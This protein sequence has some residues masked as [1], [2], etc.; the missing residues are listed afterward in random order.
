MKT[1]RKHQLLALV[2]L[3]A[4]LATVA[5][6]A[7]ADRA[8]E[9]RRPHPGTSE[10]LKEAKLIIEHNATDHDTGFQG[11]LDS[12]G[13]DRIEMIGPRGPQLDFKGVGSLG[14]L[15]LTELFFETVEPSNDDKPIAELLQDMPAGTYTFEGRTMIDGESSGRTIG[16]AELSHVIPD[17]PALLYPSENAVVSPDGFEARWGAVTQSIHGGPVDIISYQ[18][19]IQRDV[20]PHPRMIGK[21]GLSMYLPASTLSMAIPREFLQPGTA[22]KWEVLAID[23]SGNQTLSSGEFST[24]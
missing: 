21:W 3:V 23:K 8:R 15:G 12:E 20:P 24:R 14:E 11:F 10:P 22:Y 13:W 4:A 5:G 18:L 2:A 1:T 17:G 19:I 7:L 16:T 9:R 6:A